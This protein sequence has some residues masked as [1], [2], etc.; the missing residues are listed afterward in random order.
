MADNAKPSND[1]GKVL[2][3][4]KEKYFVP[5]LQASVEAESLDEAT[6]LAEKELASR[7]S[8]KTKGQ[9]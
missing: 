7:K 6:K 8:E 3:T 5:A 2:V 4:P 1:N 9:N